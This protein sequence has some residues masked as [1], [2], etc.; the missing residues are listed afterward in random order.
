MSFSFQMVDSSIDDPLLLQ[1]P[2]GAGRSQQGALNDRARTPDENAVFDGWQQ[3]LD[4]RVACS[5]QSK[6]DASR[7]DEGSR[8]DTMAQN[9]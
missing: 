1:E 5:A 9:G 2:I 4:S 6:C 3:G 7:D 8:P